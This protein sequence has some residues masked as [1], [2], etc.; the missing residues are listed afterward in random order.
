MSAKPIGIIIATAWEAG[1]VIKALGLR[2][3]DGL[4]QG[5]QQSRRVLLIV[6]GVGPQ[7]AA[8][9]A[10]RLCSLGAKGLVS[11][12]FCGAL[13]PELQVGQVVTDRIISTATPVKTS[14][15]R[16]ALTIRA[17]AVAVDMETQS[18]IES[19]TRRGVPIFICRV[20]SDRFEDDL[21]PLFGQDAGFSA[22]R[23]ALRLLNP[24]VWPLAMK[25]RRQSAVAHSALVRSL[26]QLL[27]HTLLN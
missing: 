27:Q 18:V 21:T 19:G 1:P 16:Q 14:A 25:L 20:V 11:A 6:S 12:G 15:E 4:Y 10:N 8:A 22:M 13:V 23:I 17:N 26:T 7:A 9:A 2:Q 24:T 5:E 3:C